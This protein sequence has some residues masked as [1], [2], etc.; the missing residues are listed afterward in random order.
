MAKEEGLSADKRT[1]LV[2]SDCR[3]AELTVIGWRMSLVREGRAVSSVVSDFPA[4]Q[5][6]H[7]MQ[8]D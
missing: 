5:R 1:M 2:K 8:G 7:K 4:V 3:E 6:Y